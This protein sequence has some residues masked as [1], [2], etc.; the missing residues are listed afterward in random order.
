MLRQNLGKAM[1]SPCRVASVVHQTPPERDFV[2]V[3]L[4]VSKG[5]N[6]QHHGCQHYQAYS[7]SYSSPLPKPPRPSLAQ[8]VAT[9]HHQSHYGGQRQVHSTIAGRL[10]QGH[11]TGRRRQ[12][13]EEQRPQNRPASTL[14]HS[15]DGHRQEKSQK[16]RPG[17]DG[18]DRLCEGNGIFVALTHRPEHH[19]QIEQ[20]HTW[21]RADIGPDLG[22]VDP[23]GVGGIRASHQAGQQ[24]PTDCQAEVQSPPSPQGLAKRSS[25]EGPVVQQHH[26]RSGGHDLLGQ[27][28]QPAASHRR[29]IPEHGPRR[30]PG[31]DDA[32]EHQQIEQS[33]QRL[34]PLHDI[35]HRLPL[36]RMDQP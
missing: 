25:P 27:R 10:N 2:S 11:D 17:Q 9:Q 18:T 5:Q 33:R 13:Q 4:V 16:A 1:E 36:Q 14:H 7:D 35:R 19:P 21:L 28:S 23:L 32:V 8:S 26:Q 20:D 24:A 12:N 34:R 3:D 30:L 22:R 15:P 6:T 31:T 29:K